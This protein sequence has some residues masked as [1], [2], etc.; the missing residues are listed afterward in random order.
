MTRIVEQKAAH[1]GARPVD[2]RDGSGHLDRAYEKKLRARARDGV[3]PTERAFVHGSSSAN[4]SA[5]RA[6]EEFV[7]AA[8]TGEEGGAPELE[9]MTPEESGGPFVATTGRAEF[10][11]GTDASNPRDGTREPFP[12]TR[13]R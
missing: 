5:E 7:L 12:T 4:A 8:T 3:R 1:P 11:H 13:S 10:A 9:E 2:H 6:G